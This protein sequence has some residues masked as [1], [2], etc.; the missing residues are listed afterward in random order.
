MRKFDFHTHP[1]LATSC[2]LDILLTNSTGFVFFS[3]AHLSSHILSSAARSQLVLS[4]FCLLICFF[5][6]QIHTFIKFLSILF[7][8]TDNTNVNFFC[9]YRKSSSC[10]PASSNMFSLSLKVSP[11]VFS[12]FL[13]LLLIV[14][15]FFH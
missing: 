1:A 7:I 6:C 13:L 14:S 2:F 11:T 8:T 12:K 9:Q 10:S 4:L 3:L 15:L 5:F